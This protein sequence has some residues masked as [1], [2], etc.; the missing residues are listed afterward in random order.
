MNDVAFGI[1]CHRPPQSSR[2]ATRRSLFPLFTL[3]LFPLAATPT[4]AERLIASP[5]ARPSAKARSGYGQPEQAVLY[6][7]DPTRVTSGGRYGGSVLWHT[8]AIKHDDR[9]KANIAVR[10]DVDIPERKFRMTMLIFRNTDPAVAASHSAEF[11]FNLPADFGGG[12]IREMPGM[13]MKPSEQG[14]G[15]PLSGSVARVA[16]GVFRLNLSNVD[17]E[18]AQ[19]IQ[20]LQGGPWFS[21][22]MIY[23]NLHRAIITIEKGK[24]GYQAFKLAFGA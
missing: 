4:I 9:D 19:N 21:I 22:P 11:R 18:R 14:H 23:D 5:A 8:E 12:G 16:D 24:S 17:A 10:A 6:E 1:A 13:L 7:E 20:V 3:A 2:L 15:V